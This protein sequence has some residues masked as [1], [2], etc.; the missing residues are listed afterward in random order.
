ME[1]VNCQWCGAKGDGNFCG[2]CGRHLPF[3]NIPKAPSVAAI[4]KTYQKPIPKNA[5][6]AWVAR[7]LGL[8]VATAAVT[9]FINLAPG[10]G[11][12][13]SLLALYM[14]FVPQPNPDLKT[15]KVICPH[16]HERGGVTTKQVRLKKGVSG[17]KAT[18]ALLT[19]GVSLLV[20]GLSRKENMTQA[21]CSCC[22]QVWH[23]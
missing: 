16:C 17:A 11:A 12:G 5:P 23:Y 14:L 1:Q 7:F 6:D 2:K 3:Q 8:I 20:V 22:G 18:G 15:S 19:G 10:W 13:L 21:S 4:K 9:C